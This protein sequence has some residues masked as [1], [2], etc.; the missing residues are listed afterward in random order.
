MLG[1]SHD[2][3]NDPK[4]G[5]VWDLPCSSFSFKKVFIPDSKLTQIIAVPSANN[6]H[7]IQT[8]S[9]TTGL[10]QWYN[11]GLVVT[12]MVDTAYSCI[13]KVMSSN[14][15]DLPDICFVTK[16]GK[17]LSIQCLIGVSVTVKQIIKRVKPGSYFLRMQCEF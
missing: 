12:Y 5:V 17:V 3:G 15:S 6:T 1:E 2:I 7:R 8:S 10:A 14:P 13:E 4:V 16:L 9:I 11:H